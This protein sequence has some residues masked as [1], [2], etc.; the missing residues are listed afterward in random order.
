[1]AAVVVL[2]AV[3]YWR[4][5]D[6][7][8]LVRDD[9]QLML[10]SHR[11]AAGG[12]GEI[13]APQDEHFQPLFRL[14]RL[15]FDLRFPERYAGL[16]ALV[17]AAHAASV[18]LL[19]LVARRYTRSVWA[20]VVTA[21]FFG[22]SST[23]LHAFAWKAAS[24]FVLAW[25]FL[26][27]AVYCLARGWVAGA[28]ACQLAAVGMFTGTTA[29]LPGIL[30]GYWWLERG[31]DR[32]ALACCAGAMLAGLG[33]WA[34]FVWPFLDPARHLRGGM[35][36]LVRQAGEA[37]AATLH[38]YAILGARAVGSEREAAAWWLAAPIAVI[39]VTAGRRW[40]LRWP[41]VG[42]A[43]SVL[44][45][46]AIFLGRRF[47]GAE[48]APRY[49]YQSFAFWAIAVGYAVDV[50]LAAAPWRR[51]LAAL[52]VL[53]G[54]LYYGRHWQVVDEGRRIWRQGEEAR[55]EFW[56]GW[57]DMLRLA[58]ER[59][60]A[61]TRVLVPWDRVWERHNVQTMARLMRVE[62]LRVARGAGTEAEEFWFWREL[63][64]RGMEMLPPAPRRI[65]GSLEREF[66]RVGELSWQEVAPGWAQ[67]LRIEAP[68]PAEVQMWVEP[69]GDSR[70]YRLGSR[71]A[72]RWWVAAGAVPGWKQGGELRLRMTGAGSTLVRG[73]ARGLF[74]LT[75]PNRDRQGA[76]LRFAE[77]SARSRS[78]FGDGQ[79]R[80]LSY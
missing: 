79:A 71:Q 59:Q 47:E 74:P 45:L 28:L 33:A 36:G 30:L 35:W 29:V 32:R 62:G 48:Y 31:R 50:L 56:R 68:A 43:W 34:L 57:K 63:G 1:V 20:A 51:V 5:V 60:V 23:G 19:F 2:S 75:P 73:Q 67:W 40:S 44:L 21:A 46:F 6:T 49:A 11:I 64:T 9:T 77:P 14:A 24:H 39:F 69:R 18:W 61:V 72:T 7:W 26:L 27:G 54:G 12:W 8:I 66:R 58:G 70:P 41:G 22:W 42:A 10:A 80:G 13:L 65:H 76:D 4:A 16:H 52:L 55:P 37:L 25:P 3:Q 53:G 38:A 78:R 15:W 17:V